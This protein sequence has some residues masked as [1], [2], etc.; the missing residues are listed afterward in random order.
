MVVFTSV[1]T[2]LPM[3]LMGNDWAAAGFH[4]QNEGDGDDDD[5]DD[6]NG[7]DVAPAA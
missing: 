6:D 5:D 2:G 3:F 7:I 4:R 1:D